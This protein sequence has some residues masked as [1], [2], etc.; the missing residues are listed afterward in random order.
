MFI[1]TPGGGRLGYDPR[2]GQSYKL[3]NGYYGNEAFL[4]DPL[5][6]NTPPVTDVLKTL[7]ASELSTGQH[8]VYVIG[9][10]TGTYKY[11]GLVHDA[12]GHEH[13]FMYTTETASGMVDVY[14]FDVTTGEFKLLPIDALLFK[15][16]IDGE[17]KDATLNRFFTMWAEKIMG[18][19]KDGKMTQ[20]REHIETFKTLMKA[21]KVDSPALNLL[22]QKLAA[23]VG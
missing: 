5:D 13:P 8:K 18:E 3:T 15:G 23:Q 7:S 2:A 1:S 14:Q 22:L 21:K 4:S 19:I 17:I 12:G 20:A 11:A 6:E 9:T 10:G 16:V